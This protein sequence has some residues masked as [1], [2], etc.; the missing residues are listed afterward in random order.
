MFPARPCRFRQENGER[1]GGTRCPALEPETGRIY[2]LLILILALICASLPGGG[3]RLRE[4]L[5]LR[6]A[7][8]VPSRRNPVIRFAGAA[9]LPDDAAA[10]RTTRARHLCGRRRESRATFT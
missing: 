3:L 10:A 5:R 1:A 6:K 7:P 2:S 9:P 8:N 4:R